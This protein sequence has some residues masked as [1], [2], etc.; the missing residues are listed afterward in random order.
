MHSCCS[1]P[2]PALLSV[3]CAAEPVCMHGLEREHR[4]R[5]C[6][7]EPC[8][9]QPHSPTYMHCGIH[10]WQSL[11]EHGSMHAA[12]CSAAK[13][14]LQQQQRRHVSCSSLSEDQHICSRHVCVAV[15]QAVQE[16][17]CSTPGLR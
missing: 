8:M 6:M 13:G 4:L 11:S 7:P 1:S 12:S 16:Q 5:M 9:Q 10:C 15:R 3:S 14:E 2:A 17:T